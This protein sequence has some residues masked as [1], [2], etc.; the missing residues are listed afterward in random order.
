MTEEESKGYRGCPSGLHLAQHQRCEWSEDSI[1]AKQII[2]RIRQ[3]SYTPTDCD[4]LS[5]FVDDSEAMRDALVKIRDKCQEAGV[6]FEE[7]SF[8]NTE[9]ARK[10]LT[11]SPTQP[12][13]MR[14]TR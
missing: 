12:P 6:G 8:D 14:K 3:G 10:A 2:A 9:V 13:T 11:H 4:I 5:Q 1:V 7:Q